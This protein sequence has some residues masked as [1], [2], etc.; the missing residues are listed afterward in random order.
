MR[1]NR[2]TSGVASV[3]FVAFAS[4]ILVLSFLSAAGFM[5]VPA[6]AEELHPPRLVDGA[7]L[8]D[9][10][11]TDHVRQI[12]DQY[13]TELQFDIVIVTTS[14]LGGK[15]PR[16][17]ADDYYDYN[18]Y[19]YGEEKDGVLLLRYFVAPKSPENKVWMSTTGE[20]IKIFSDSDIQSVFD[21][22]VDDFDAGRY[23]GAFLTFAD[24]VRAEVRDA[25]SYNTIWIFIGLAVGLGIGLTVTGVMR[26]SLKSVRQKRYAGNYVKDGSL[27]I[28]DARDIFL[29]RTVTRVAKPKES[30]G[31]SST[32]TGSSG[33]SH[34]GGGRSM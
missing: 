1:M 29:Y 19:G 28:T 12:L 24:D 15:S 14:D 3:A 4:F 25:R 22:M 32:H 16:D 5:V 34:G 13:S 20:G 9:V 30:S 27:N 7:G 26:A 23:Y 2:S 8:L 31:G 18:G 21:D 17:F 33:R 11:E 10:D 6:A